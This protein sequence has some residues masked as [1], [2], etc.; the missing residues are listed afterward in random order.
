MSVIAI[1][2][3]IPHI[4]KEELAVSRI[5]KASE[6]ATKHGAKSSLWKV[7]AGHGAGD[8]VM[9]NNYESFT[10][11]AIAFEGFSKDPEMVNLNKERGTNPAADLRGP[12]VFRMAYGVPSNPPR[13]VLVQ[14]F[15]QMPRKHMTSVLALAPELD[16]LMQNQDVTI[17]VGVP[18]LA[19]DHEMMGVVY[20]FNSMEHWGKAVDAMV[21]DQEFAALVE[22][23]NE[24]GTLKA[25]R[26]LLSI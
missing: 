3:F 22:R 18:I 20:R 25:S 8:Y 23:A 14:R 6:I 5:T 13:P 1:R 15:Y 12:N 4:G 2:E 21:E 7:S 16:K 9:M 11:G 26:M 19:G 10:K 24:L 17:G